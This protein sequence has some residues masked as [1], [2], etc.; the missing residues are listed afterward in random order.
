MLRLAPVRYVVK[1]FTD[2]NGARLNRRE[3]KG[4]TF[5]IFSPSN[6]TA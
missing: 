3:A 2:L 6:F 4:F 5:G 1:S